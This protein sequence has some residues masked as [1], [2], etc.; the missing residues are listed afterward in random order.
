MTIIERLE[1]AGWTLVERR[2]DRWAWHWRGDWRI[3]T[4]GPP[5]FGA[6]LVLRTMNQGHVELSACEAEHAW[7]ADA[8]RALMARRLA[9][10]SVAQFCG[11][12]P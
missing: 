1:A 10:V 5:P 3:E 9:A 7:P 4:T 11:V 2:H 8:V 12:Q 6:R